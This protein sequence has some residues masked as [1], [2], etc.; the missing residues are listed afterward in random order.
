MQFMAVRIRLARFGKKNSPHYR[1]AVADSRRWR[2]G[3]V[4]EYIGTYNP[5]NKDDGFKV[6]LDRYQH[7]LGNGAQASQTVASLVSKLK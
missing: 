1:V 7:W 3:K 2:D 5:F 6:D 4:I